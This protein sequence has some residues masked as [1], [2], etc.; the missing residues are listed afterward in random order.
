MM[1]GRLSF[2]YTYWAETPVWIAWAILNNAH[3]ITGENGG[4]GQKVGMASKFSRAQIIKHPPLL[5]PGYAT[6]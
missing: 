2:H 6:V 5:N 1:R 3:P 4:C